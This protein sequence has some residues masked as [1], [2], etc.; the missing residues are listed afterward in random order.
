MSTTPRR[1]TTAAVL[2]VGALLSVTGCNESDTAA[3]VDGRVISESAAREAAHQIATNFQGAEGFTTADAVGSLINAPF[4]LAAADKAGH[5]YSEQA[6]RAQMTKVSDP[7]PETIEL[8]R[9]NF[10]YAQLQQTAPDAAQDIIAGLRKAHITVN[11]RYGHFDKEQ[12]AIA[13]TT[14]NWIATPAVDDVT[15]TDGPTEPAPADSPTEPAPADSS[16]STPA[17]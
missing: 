16:S 6:A 13:P 1:R 8:V 5:P 11:P 2:A 14:P 15:P 12:L 9:A 17:G 3:T 10:A 4:I 7:L